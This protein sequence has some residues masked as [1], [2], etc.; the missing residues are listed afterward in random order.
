MPEV[1]AEKFAAPVP[2]AVRAAKEQAEKLQKELINPTPPNGEPPQ[3]P[4]QPPDEPEEEPVIEAQPQEPP[5]PPQPPDEPDENHDT[6]KHKFQ[7]MQGRYNSEVPKLRDQIKQMSADIGNLNRLLATVEQPAP[8]PAPAAVEKPL[9]TPD[10]IAEYGPE[11][12]D[13]IARVSKQ[14]N[15]E[16][17]KEI[18]ELKAQL[19]QVGTHVATNARDQLLKDLASE[20]PNWSELNESKEFVDWLALPDPYS[21]DIRHKMLRSAFGRNDSRRVINFFKGFLAESAATA[22]ADEEEPGQKGIVPKVPLRDLAAPGRAK[23]TAAPSKTPAEKP[24]FTTPQIT[25]FYTDKANGKYRG[26]E[27]V[28]ADF[29]AAIFLAQAEGRIR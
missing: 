26:R 5:Q 14:A 10:E 8:A 6:W 9:V 24:I 15:A 7:S 20:V 18:A 11:M 17:A 22:P 1:N 28:A 3:E 23:S 16:Q 29:E 19:A 4:P 25:A 27:K 2:A 12:M 21:G 13:L